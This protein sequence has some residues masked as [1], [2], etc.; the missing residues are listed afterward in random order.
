MGEALELERPNWVLVQGDTNSTLAGALAALLRA[1]DRR[2]IG[3]ANQAKA[4][5]EF[6]EARMAERYLR[7][8]EG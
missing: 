2:E 6:D 4:R 1:P 8:I 3:R 7:L 5:A